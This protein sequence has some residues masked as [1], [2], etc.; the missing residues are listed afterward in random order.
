MIKLNKYSRDIS[1]IISFGLSMLIPACGSKNPSSITS[2]SQEIKTDSVMVFVLQQ[3]SVKKDL[4]LPGELLPN[5]TA[6][7]RAKVQGYIRKV[8]VDI[9][10]VVRK[11][12]I[13][14]LIDAPEIN[15]KTSEINAK[16]K[17]AEARF[18]SSKDYYERIS[19]ASKADGV[20]AAS[21]LQRTRDQMLADEA[22]FK[23]AKFSA[24]SFRQLGSYLAI[25]APYNGVITK[26]NIDPGSFVGNANEQP[27][28]ELQDNAT[29]KLMVAIPEAY[30]GAVLL[31]K[32][33]D[34]TTRSFPDRKFRAKL[35]RKA[36]SIDNAT[37]SEL[38]EFQVP[39]S[40]RELKAGSYA[41]VKLHFL[42][43]NPSLT[44]PSSAI[45][46]TLERKFVIRVSDN[47]AEWI[48]VRTGFNM[49]DKQEIFG[50]LHPGDTL[51][52]KANEE[53][54]PG[55][56]LITKQIKSIK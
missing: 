15:S 51:V 39:N 26:K 17:A 14:A 4:S 34:L 1:I 20:I 41:D 13:L 2:K 48:D 53:L 52:L 29:L 16:V 22:E 28:F 8:N 44:V 49:A 40:G 30:T 36:G 5:E 27:L 25:I 11:G 46:T 3:D 55:T 6:Q 42:R 21:E 32:A 12:Q 38:W 54:K 45:V 56:K 50:D 23:A 19:S 7:I 9:G 37:R 47:T 18:Q 31:G 43:L 33:G 10:S 24:A 35:V